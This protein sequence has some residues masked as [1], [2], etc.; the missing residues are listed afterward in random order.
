MRSILAAAALLIVMGATPSMA[1]EYPW[2]SRTSAT[3][4]NPSCTFTSYNQCMATVSGQR[5]DCMQNPMLAYGDQRRGQSRAMRGQP[6]DW[7]N[8][9]NNGWNN[10]WDR[11]W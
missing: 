8:G 3:G 11:R 7:D 6:D 2:C 9:W 4:F 5:G 1:R 10:N